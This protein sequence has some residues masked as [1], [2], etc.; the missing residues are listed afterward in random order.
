[1]SSI[2]RTSSSTLNAGG[3]LSY[4]FVI[5]PGTTS[6]INVIDLT[7]QDS[8]GHTI[9]VQQTGLTSGTASVAST[10]SWLNGSYT[11]T[12]ILVQDTQ[13][14]RSVYLPNGTISYPFG[15]TG[16]SSSSISFSSL[17]F[18]LTGGI[19]PGTAPMISVQPVSQTVL[20]GGSATFTVTAAGTPAP[21]YQWNFNGTAIAGATGSS[22]SV[23]NALAANAGSYTV[24]VSN[25]AGSVTSSAATLTV[26]P[27]STGGSSVASPT[28]TAQPVSATT[29]VGYLA[30]FSVTA[31]PYPG[32]NYQWYKN[33]A[34]IPGATS[35]LYTIAAAALTD[36]GSYTVVVSDSAGSVTSSAATLT[37]NP[38]GSAIPPAVPPVITIQPTG[39][40]LSAGQS[41]A[42]SVAATGAT[43]YQWYLNGVA[44]P[45]A[46][47]ST[48]NLPSVQAAN[49]G[50]YTVVAS[51]GAGSVTS[52]TAS[53]AL[54]MPAHLANLS[55]R[56]LV[57]TGSNELIV[58]FVVGGSGTKQLLLRA[59]GPSLSNFGLT[60]VLANPV[61]SLTDGNGNFLSSNT[62]WSTSSMS[63]ATLS[64]V[65]NRVGAYA[66]PSGSADSALVTALGGGNFTTQ[67]SGLSGGTGV[68]LA[69]IYDADIGTPTARLINISARANVGTGPNILIAGFV[70]AGSGTERVLIRG[71]GP[72]LTTYGL[73]GAL[74][75]PQLTLYS[76]GGVLIASNLNGWSN[77]PVVGPSSPVAASSI[78]PAT[79]AAMANAGAF[80]LAAG[81][82]DTAMLVTLPSG[83]YT[84]QI[85]GANT[86]VGISLIEVYEA[87]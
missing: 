5:T 4:S 36:A 71:I 17:G 26:N 12:Q 74:A 10:A 54:V 7:I 8:S 29:T 18:S 49:A 82:S 80:A 40:S 76:A 63:A 85:A 83:S 57:G 72:A 37:V 75:T 61:L 38:T 77:P 31:T 45:G 30:Q 68:A 42:L 20:T 32:T 58:G 47:G 19:S 13:G 25:S 73:S 9:D 34:L 46:T 59:D 6:T 69:E 65:F 78:Q 56:A 87:P 55:A 66:Y 2:I 35:F 41:V 28:I 33:G 16:P 81:S 50:A 51:N 53:I 86:S 21:T 43:S 52:S 48:L 27:A 79:A 15:G 14:I 1:L 23:N 44:V 64:Q 60:G 62:G 11:V 39:G 22:Y 3:T 70:V 67:V 24:L 84:A